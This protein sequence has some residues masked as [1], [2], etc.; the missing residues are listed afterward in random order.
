MVQ[1]KSSGHA[2]EVLLDRVGKY[3][4]SPA[5]HQAEARGSLVVSKPSR[6]ASEACQVQV[7][8]L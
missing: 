6:W 1:L 3:E 7:L 5:K 8:P 2:G 4:S